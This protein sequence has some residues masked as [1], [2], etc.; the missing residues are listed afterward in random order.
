MPC[1]HEHPLP[2]NGQRAKRVASKY[3]GERV[4]KASKY[5]VKQPAVVM[6]V[7]EPNSQ[8]MLN[9]RRCMTGKAPNDYDTRQAS[10]RRKE[11]DQASRSRASETEMETVGVASEQ[12][13]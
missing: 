8:R 5:P 9:F 7:P 13:R 6:D 11:R 12:Y 4:S 1:L 2:E 10:H 3:F